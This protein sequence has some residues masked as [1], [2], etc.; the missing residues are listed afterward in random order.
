MAMT[1]LEQ[2]ANSGRNNAGYG[3]HSASAPT[4]N[5]WLAT[6]GNSNFGGVHWTSGACWHGSARRARRAVDEHSSFLSHH[7]KS[8]IT[9][10]DIQ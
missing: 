4:A 8:M 5:I 3:V 10:M 7:Q 2:N 6:A 9:S 1:S